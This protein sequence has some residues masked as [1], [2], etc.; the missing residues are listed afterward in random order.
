MNLQVN[1]GFAEATDEL[2]YEPRVPIEQLKQYGFYGYLIDMIE[3]PA[4]ILNMLC[5]LYGIHN[6]AVGDD[7]TFQVAGTVPDCIRKFYS[8]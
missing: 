1:V 3:G 2:L 6:I 7:R 5:S 4:P 8:S